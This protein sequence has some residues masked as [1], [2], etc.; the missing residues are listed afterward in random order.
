MEVHMLQELPL[1]NLKNPKKMK[2]EDA[3]I[4]FGHPDLTTRMAIDLHEELKKWLI[5]CLIIYKK[6]FAWSPQEVRGI[7][8]EIIEHRINIFTN[9]KSIKQKKRHFGLEKDR[10][11]RVEINKLLKAGYIREIQFPI[12]LANVVLV[13]KLGSK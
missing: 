8:P 7:S 12:W 6:V 13:S 10:I 2:W 3:P 9:A 11:I 5:K 1:S 4:V